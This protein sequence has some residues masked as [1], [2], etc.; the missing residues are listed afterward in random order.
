MIDTGAYHP[1]RIFYMPSVP[2]HSPRPAS[3]H[4]IARLFDKLGPLLS[5]SISPNPTSAY[6]HRPAL[7]R[8]SSGK[9]Y[10]EIVF[11]PVRW[12]IDRRAGWRTLTLREFCEFYGLNVKPK[13]GDADESFFRRFRKRDHNYSHDSYGD[14]GARCFV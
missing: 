8:W 2:A 7:W 14:G 1:A 6:D 5:I 12:S 3:M 10:G 11:F 13:K 9:Q 4:E